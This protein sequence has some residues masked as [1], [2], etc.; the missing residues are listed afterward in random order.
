MKIKPAPIFKGVFKITHC[1]P[2]NVV[3]YSV[4]LSFMCGS[5]R[6][7]KYQ[8]NMRKVNEDR[9]CEGPQKHHESIIKGLYDSCTIFQVF[10]SHTITLSGCNLKSN[11]SMTSNTFESPFTFIIRKQVVH[12]NGWSNMGWHWW[13]VPLR[14]IKLAFSS[15]TKASGVLP[16]TSGTVSLSHDTTDM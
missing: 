1:W 3:I 16:E 12:A 6:S 10:W 11:G 15:N 4:W 7:E 8:A 9:I 5:Q 2:Q 14:Q 13:T